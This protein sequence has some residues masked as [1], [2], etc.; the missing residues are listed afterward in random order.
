MRPSSSTPNGPAAE[1]THQAASGRCVRTGP[2]LVDVTGIIRVHPL[3]KGD[4]PN[5][6]PQSIDAA[7]AWGVEH[8]ETAR[9][10]RAVVAEA[11][12]QHAVTGTPTGS[13]PDEH[14]R[15]SSRPVVASDGLTRPCLIPGR[16]Y[17]QQGA[18][19]VA[20]DHV[21]IARLHRMPHGVGTD[22]SVFT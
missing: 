18:I 15:F 12:V 8:T 7:Y 9:Q 4:T 11:R 2:S 20:I 14:Q 5:E 10:T 17:E 1:R 3:R 22:V 16:P 21:F 19:R 6:L 13:F